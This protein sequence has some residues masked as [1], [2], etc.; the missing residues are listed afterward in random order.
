MIC[1]VNYI[2]PFVTFIAFKTIRIRPV[3][4]LKM[5][6]NPLIVTQS[7]PTFPSRCPDHVQLS[8]SSKMAIIETC[9]GRWIAY[10]E[11]G[12][13]NTFGR[14]CVSVCVC[15]CPVRA[16]TFKSLHL[17]NFIFGTQVYIFRISTSNS[18]IHQSYR[19]KVIVTGT[20]TWYAS[21]TKYTHSR[22]ELSM[23]Q[24]PTRH[25]IGHSGT[26]FL[27]VMW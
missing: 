27:Q 24:C 10:R 13:G 14:I 18:Y 4:C 12:C 7:N 15:V 26:I 1:I 23:V 3:L 19:V 17:E 25:S 8:R 9:N 22:V 6:F 11:C 5:W 16:L 2:N 21:V 20:K